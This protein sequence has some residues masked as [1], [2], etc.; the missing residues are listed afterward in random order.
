MTRLVGFLFLPTIPL[1][2][3]VVLRERISLLLERQYSPEQDDNDNSSEEEAALA[4]AHAEA[5]KWSRL[6][7]ARRGKSP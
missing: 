4:D 6:S 3:S 5:F 1:Y 7:P 2:A